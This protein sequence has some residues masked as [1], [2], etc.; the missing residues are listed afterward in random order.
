MRIYFCEFINSII[1]SIQAMLD[2]AD[3]VEALDSKLAEHLYAPHPEYDDPEFVVSGVKNYR[4]KDDFPRLIRSKVPTSI[5][6]I[7]YD[8]NLE[9][10]TAFECDKLWGED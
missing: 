2:S 3:A 7:S 4:V 10:I 5:N 9:S 8:I 6:K 1:T